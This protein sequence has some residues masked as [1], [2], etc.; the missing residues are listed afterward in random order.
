MSNGEIGVPLQL[1]SKSRNL[2]KMASLEHRLVRD[3]FG[4]FQPVCPVK[5]LGSAVVSFSALTLTTN[6]SFLLQKLL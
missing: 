6:E 5:G 4:R 3:A 2:L 1:F